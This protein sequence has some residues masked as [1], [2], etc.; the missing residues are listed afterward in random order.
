MK[1]PPK[2]PK[3]EEPN[4]VY[5]TPIAVQ[6]IVILSAFLAGSSAAWRSYNMYFI[7]HEPAVWKIFIVMICSMLFLVI[8]VYPKMWQRW[9]YFAADKK[10]CYFRCNWTLLQ[11]KDFY[12]FVPWSKIGTAYIGNILD[13]DGVSESVIIKIKNSDNEWQEKLTT[14]T[15]IPNWASF[16]KAKKDEQGYR[17]YQLGNHCRNVQKTLEEIEKIRVLS[18]V[19]E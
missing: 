8:S 7:E 14:E 15:H 17:E 19:E 10:G 9:V 3:L 2:M 4:F 6:Y 5:M 12:Y 11:N 18:K 13:S 16:I 1:Y